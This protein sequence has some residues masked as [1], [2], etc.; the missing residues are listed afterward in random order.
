MHCSPANRVERLCR[1]IQLRSS[2][3]GFGVHGGIP[4]L[5]KALKGAPYEF[6]V[7]RGDLTG[8]LHKSLIHQPTNLRTCPAPIG[9]AVGPSLW[10]LPLG[11]C[12]VQ[13]PTAEL[14]NLP[15]RKGTLRL[16]RLRESEQEITDIRRIKPAEEIGFPRESPRTLTN[17]SRENSPQALR[18]RCIK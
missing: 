1:W 11:V 7:R 16:H 4:I 17:Q 9:V 3:L 5:H 18:S 8:P 10:R 12:L 13:D 15:P 14:E 2:G 6:S